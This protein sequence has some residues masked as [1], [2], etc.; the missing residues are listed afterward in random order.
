VS[1]DPLR[2]ALDL[3]PGQLDSLARVLAPLVAAELAGRAPATPSPYLTVPEAAAHM[4]CSRQR[5]H[6]LCS[7]GRLPRV[8]DGSRTL[9]ARAD[10]DR[11]LA[12]EVTPE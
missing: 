11:Y 6:D 1:A 3:A 5:V 4:R 8:K 10:L 9:L 12:G 2:L 7:Q